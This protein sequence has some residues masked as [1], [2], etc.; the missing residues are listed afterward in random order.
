MTRSTRELGALAAVVCLGLATCFF[1][2]SGKT[3]WNDEAFSFFVSDGGAARAV[4]FIISD[5]QPPVYYLALSAW[6]HLGSTP[7]VMRSLSALA[8]TVAIPLIYDT[9]RR[10]MGIPVGVLS[11]VLF[12]TDPTC[13][14]WAQKARPY[15]LQTLFAAL[16]FWGFVRLYREPPAGRV[17][18]LGYVVGGALSM[19]T[20]QTAGFFLLGC[21]VAMGLKILGGI[22]A[23]RVLL[24]KWIVAQ[25]AL[26][27]IW[28]LWLPAFLRQIAGNLTPAQ[29]AARHANFLIGGVDVLRAVRGMLTVSTLWSLQPPFVVAYACLGVAGAVYLA[30]RSAFVPIVVPIAA[31]LAVC[32][33]AFCLVHPI[34]GY[35]V[36]TFVW[37]LIPYVI[38]IASGVW[39]LRPWYLRGAAAAVLL[40]GNGLGLANY[41]R[42]PTVPIAQV[43]AIVGCQIRPGDGVILAKSTAERWGLAYYLGP[44]FK[45][46]LAGLDVADEWNA[47][48]IVSRDQALRQKRDWVVL[49]DGEAPAVDLAALKSAMRLRLQQRVGSLLVYRFDR[50]DSP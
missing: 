28:A 16:V 22:R 20:Q 14:D 48:L 21:N 9:A 26:A 25:V 4:R 29:I 18:M 7:W 47:D 32:A 45:G 2:L 41:Y 23:H 11:A 3:L 30:R 31:P 1:D 24:G 39:L 5:T 13:V 34:F 49:P 35:V 12:A 44:P 43:A 46:R 40:A 17:P 36:Q 10:L 8:M 27:A 19:L 15:A 6:L 33:A 38:V 37:I 42:S 50:I